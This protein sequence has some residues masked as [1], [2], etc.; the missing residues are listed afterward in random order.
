MCKVHIVLQELQAAVLMLHKMAFWL[1][2]KVVALCLDNG[3]AKAYLWKQGDTASF[4]LSRL[5]CHILNLAKKHGNTVIP[6]Y[7]HAHF[8]VEADHLSREG[9]I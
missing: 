8:N 2:G 3:T 9:F 4:F 1:S 5:T 7:L 6:A